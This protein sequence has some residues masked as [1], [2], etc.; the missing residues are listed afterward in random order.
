MLLKPKTNTVRVRFNYPVSST[1]ERKNLN[2]D[3]FC[4]VF[5]IFLF[6]YAGSQKRNTCAFKMNIRI[7]QIFLLVYAWKIRVI[8]F[9]LQILFAKK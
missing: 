9:A 1:D 6:Q 4:Y 7:G 5:F 3:A 2:V 8:Q